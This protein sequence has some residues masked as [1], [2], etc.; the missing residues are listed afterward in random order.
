MPRSFTVLFVYCTDPIESCGG[1]LKRRK[2]KDG[3]F[4]DRSKCCVVKIGYTV[5]IFFF[6]LFLLLKEI[7]QR[8]K[9]FTSCFYGHNFGTL[10]AAGFLL[11][12]SLDFC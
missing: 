11:R 8:G 3:S 2:E 12:D 9:V 5:W 10:F 4:C 7:G 1:E 6:F